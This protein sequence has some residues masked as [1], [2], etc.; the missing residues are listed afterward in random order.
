MRLPDAATI[1]ALNPP[2]R[3]HP[4]RT[5]AQQTVAHE[6]QP[7]EANRVDQSISVVYHRNMQRQSQ[8]TSPLGD[9]IRKVREERAANDP[10]FS[11]RRV[12]ARC[13]VTP[14]YLSRIER[15][16]VAPPSEETL[17]RLASDLGEDRDVLLAMAGKISTDLRAIILAR[18]RLFADLIRSIK[19]MPDH[20]V[21][22]IVR[23]V[24]DGDW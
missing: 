10:A 13:E 22:R 4:Q 3:A 18:P 21:L 20:A 1:A 12:A 17:L 11:L 9:Y 5:T 8:A 16:E 23:E 7:L 14:A 19:S 24:K 2:A 15:N 6:I